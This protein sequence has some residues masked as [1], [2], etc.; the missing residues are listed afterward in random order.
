MV[1]KRIASWK[2]D[3]KRAVE[4]KGADKVSRNERKNSF[5]RAATFDDVPSVEWDQ[6]TSIARA[7]A[8]ATRRDVFPV[9]A[10]ARGWNTGFSCARALVEQNRAFCLR[11]TVAL[12]SV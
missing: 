6:G 2:L 4:A 3:V 5:A 9:G 12:E 8:K 11:S 1:H 10:G 7:E